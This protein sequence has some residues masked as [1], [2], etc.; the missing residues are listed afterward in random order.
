MLGINFTQEEM[1]MLDVPSHLSYVTLS[2]P[3]VRL[4]VYD[5]HDLSRG[6]H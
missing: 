6:L 5:Q 2:G 3:F 1:A 4:L